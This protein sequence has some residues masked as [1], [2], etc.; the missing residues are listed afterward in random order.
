MHQASRLRVPKGLPEAEG[1]SASAVGDE[2]LGSCHWFSSWGLGGSMG[3][4][5]IPMLLKVAA[6]DLT[7]WSR[8]LCSFLSNST[9]AADSA[10]PLKGFQHGTDVK[11][12]FQKSILPE[13]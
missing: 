11:I 4:A 10:E 1:G 12:C 9:F 5:D 6:F 2:E 13:V 3:S 7:S 8:V